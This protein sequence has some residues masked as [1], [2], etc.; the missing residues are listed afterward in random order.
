MKEHLAKVGPEYFSLE[1]Q[2][3]ISQ[4]DLLQTVEVLLMVITEF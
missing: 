4:Q 3:P 2:V 1:A